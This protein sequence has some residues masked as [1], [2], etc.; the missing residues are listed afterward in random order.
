ML[1][2]LPEITV[3]GGRRSHRAPITDDH[4]ASMMLQPL[5]AMDAHELG[6]NDVDGIR[7]DDRPLLL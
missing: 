2:E 4:L 5:T 1:T 6:N 7:L 3:Q